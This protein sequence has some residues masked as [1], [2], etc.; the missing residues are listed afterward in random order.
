MSE[1]KN[2]PLKYIMPFVP[3]LALIIVITTIFNDT[4][5]LGY[6]AGEILINHPWI[7]NI[8]L[9][10]IGINCIIILIGILELFWKLG[11]PNIKFFG[12]ARTEGR[13]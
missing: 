7:L 5:S 1:K 11:H 3:V 2:N 13:S 10:S 4:P 6:Y 12:K 8:A 9:G